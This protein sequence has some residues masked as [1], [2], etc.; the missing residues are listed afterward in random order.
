MPTLD[1]FRVIELA[2]IGPGPHAAMLL[3][4]LGADVVRVQRPVTT[5]QPSGTPDVRLRGRRIVEADL[6]HNPDR[7]TVWQLV[8]HADVLIEGFR[9]GIT[10]RLGLG[11]QECLHRN[12]RL[13]YGRMT[14][15]GQTGRLAQRAG[16][17][18]NYIA[19]TGILNAIGRPDERPVPPLN[20]VGD[21]GGGSMFLVAGVLAALLERTRSGR[22]QVVD[23]A[24]V[25]GVSVLAHMMWAQRGTGQWSDE[26]G[27]NLLDGSAPFY[28]TYECADGKYVAVGAIEPQFYQELVDGLG[29][30]DLPAQWDR[31]A[32]PDL[33]AR[34][35]R[36]FARCTRD[37]WSVHFAGRDACVSPVLTF[38]EA[39][40]YPHLVDRH[41]LADVHGVT[42]PRPAP[43][44]SRTDIAQP[45]RTDDTP[46]DATTVLRSWARADT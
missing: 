32:W 11:P 33:R 44:F 25:D 31:C 14:G 4:D 39:T 7:D 40:S 29:L 10:E 41:T 6:K 8:S 30:E 28:D 34:I 45:A 9:P 42:Q 21:F 17:D 24:M 38:D 19:A 1:G 43:R 35:A 36:T 15:W 37:E 5:A 18:I 2:G 13:V 3:A 20:L 46:T 26:R 12:P 27:S 16:H 22:G 23:A